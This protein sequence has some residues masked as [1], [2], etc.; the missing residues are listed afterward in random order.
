[1][2]IFVLQISIIDNGYILFCKLQILIMAIFVLQIAII[3][4]GYFFY[5]LKLLIMA[6]FC[7]AN[8]N[9]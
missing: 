1:M 7:F 4:I 6:I 2:A 9:Y 3:D 5:K 8:C